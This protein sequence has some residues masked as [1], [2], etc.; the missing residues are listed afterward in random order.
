MVTTATATE[1]GRQAALQQDTRHGQ[2]KTRL[3]GFVKL[4]PAGIVFF[5]VFRGR[6]AAQQSTARRR[7]MVMGDGL[8]L[9]FG[10]RTQK[11][12]LQ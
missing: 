9:H 1:S 8:I 4:P 6:S 11:Q 12:M 2:D 3:L 7:W 10:T 5:F